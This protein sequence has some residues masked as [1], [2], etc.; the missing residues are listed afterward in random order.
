MPKRDSSEDFPITLKTAA[1]TIEERERLHRTL[2]INERVQ[3]S[4]LALLLGAQT[5]IVD[6]EE[7]VWNE[8]SKKFDSTYSQ[9]MTEG[10][11]LRVSWATGIVELR[12]KDILDKDA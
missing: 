1:L 5:K 11:L 4:I 10:K 8:L 7:A 9:I 12:C 6:R 3:E 2:T